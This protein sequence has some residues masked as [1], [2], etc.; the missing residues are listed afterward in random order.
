ME[1]IEGRRRHVRELL[2]AVAVEEAAATEVKASKLP[3]TILPRK[4]SPCKFAHARTAHTRARADQWGY[5][6]PVRARDRNQFVFALP[7]FGSHG[8]TLLILLTLI[9]TV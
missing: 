8:L 2:R 1:L 9:L 5:F 3:S 7:R 6:W 4:K